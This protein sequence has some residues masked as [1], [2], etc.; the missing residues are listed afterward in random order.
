MPFDS[1]ATQDDRDFQQDAATAS[2]GLRIIDPSLSDYERSQVADSLRPD[3]MRLAQ[4]TQ[5]RGQLNQMDRESRGFLRNENAIADRRLEFDSFQNELGGM[6]N[7]D[8]QGNMEQYATMSRKYAGNPE[9]QK[10]L[11]DASSMESKLANVPKQVL[12]SQKATDD[13]NDY[14]AYDEADRKKARLINDTQM[15]TMLATAEMGWKAAEEKQAVEGFADDAHISNLAGT[16]YKQY[17]KAGDA[18]VGFRPRAEMLNLDTA[19]IKAVENLGA[20]LSNS[21]IYEQVEGVGMAKHKNLI[22]NLSAMTG[23]DFMTLSPEEQAAK[24]NGL[25]RL[26]D[27]KRP[28]PD[29]LG[30]KRANEALEAMS[31][32]NEALGTRQTLADGMTELLSNMPEPTDTKGITEWKA[33]ARQLSMKGNIINGGIKQVLNE[34]KMEIDTRDQQL[35]VD[36][37]ISKINARVK[38]MQVA[39]KRVAIAEGLAALKERGYNDSQL[40]KAK[41]LLDDTDIAAELTDEDEV[42][43]F[44]NR[45]NTKVKANQPGN[46][47]YAPK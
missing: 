6:E 7:G 10:M 26:D 35:K 22:N 30:Q 1:I 9:I 28:V 24:I 2:R 16:F 14:N 15:K 33:K 23:K 5:M 37:Q 13:L 19:S 41:D 3:M 27:K 46:N 11:S 40:L 29:I 47:L 39:D 42:I 36:D 21:M 45:F 4:M 17:P 34:R 38:G 43:N 12:E 32:Y 8:L 20:I 31:K 25:T 44:V 18:L